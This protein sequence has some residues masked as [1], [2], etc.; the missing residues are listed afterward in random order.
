V[1]GIV[2]FLIITV[3]QFIVIAKGAE[4]V[5][6]V[7]ARFTLDALPG[8]QMSID[9]DVRA[10]AITQAEAVVRRRD[11]LKE[12][13]FYGA[14]DGAMK[15]VKGDAIA[16]IVIVLVNLL[17]GIAIGTLVMDLGFGAAVKKFS[18][19]SIGDGLVTQIPALFLSIAAGVAITRTESENSAHLG[20]QIGRQLGAQPRALMLAAGVMLLFAFVPGFPALVFVILAGLA[21]LMALLLGRSA[22]AQVRLQATVEVPAAAREGEQ[23]PALLQAARALGRPPSA[24]RLEISETLAE[25]LGAADLDRALSLER[26]RLRED[27]GIPFPGIALQTS[28]TLPAQAFA[29]S[30]QDLVELVA[31]VPPGAVLAIGPAVAA[32]V[33]LADNGLTALD[34]AVPELLRPA[35]WLPA[36]DADRAA[37]AGLDILSPAHVVARTVMGVIQKNPACALGVQEVRQLVREI[38]WRFPDLVRE[39]QA[40]IPLP[41]IADL[42]AALARERVPLT[43]FPGLLQSLVTNGGSAADT[44]TIYEGARLALARSIV[45]R[46]LRPGDVRLAV[47]ALE[48]EMENRLRAALVIKPDGPVLALAPDAIEAVA[49]ALQAALQAAADRGNPVLLLAP[50]V[51]R[52]TSRLLRAQMPNTAFISHDELAASGVAPEVVG[53]AA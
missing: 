37:A 27:Y 50:D 38:E 35:L 11:M 16:G 26:G 34:E 18:I 3:V 22:K 15:F 48:P 17:G 39:V 42:M 10:G 19:L 43:D 47:V 46:Q 36:A 28:A 21:G 23:Q 12:S 45:A 44:H 13:Q 1:V 41:R 40:V 20:E 30:V 49:K 2:V 9:A 6:E 31:T 5:A 53:K 4:R 7:G 32:T 8:K 14:M 51:R 33:A 29:L 24:F 25:R 52:A